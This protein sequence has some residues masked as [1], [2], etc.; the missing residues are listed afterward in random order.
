MSEDLEVK[1]LDAAIRCLVGIKNGLL[2][3]ADNID[4]VLVEL[5]RIVAELLAEKR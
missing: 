3:R 4:T 5:R 2:K 1:Q